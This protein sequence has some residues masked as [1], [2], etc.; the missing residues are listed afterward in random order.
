MSH[1]VSYSKLFTPPKF[2]ER[3]AV[4]LEIESNGISFLSTKK[5]EKGI[6]PDLSGFIPLADGVVS[7]GEILKPEPVIKALIDIRKKTKLKFVR[8]SIPEE[9]TYI[10]KIH[11][12]NLKPKEIRDILDFKI[13]ENV[14]LSAKEAVFDYDILPSSSEN[15]GLDLMVSVA[16]LKTIEDF[17][18]VFNQAGLI[19]VL[20]SP[21]SQNVA[22]SVISETNE[23]VIVLVNIRESNIVLS[24]VIHGTVCQTEILNFG[25][26]TFTDLLAKYYKVSFAEALKIKSEKLYS[27]NS[28]NMEIF[29]YLI[30]TVSAI[31][32]EVN[33]FISYCNEKN[34]CSPVD[35]VLLCGRDALIFGLEKYL[36]LNLDI[37]VDIA[38]VW[39][40][41][42]DLNTYIP[43]M[44]KSESMNLAAVIGLN[45]F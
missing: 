23:Q 31:K 16:S 32:D 10:F 39:L 1:K 42:F 8:F 33:K 15:S 12:P 30:N 41:N 7:A 27:A 44:S 4:S 37:K 6:L 3:P 36:S 14:P 35:R 13:E 26:S 17:Q 2:L 11:L 9:K 22:K 28:E 34:D 45:L 19:S 20:F 25:S 21:E 38:N 40:N 5:T 24:R 43:D 29:S 18:T